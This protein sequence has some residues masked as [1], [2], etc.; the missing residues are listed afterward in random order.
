MSALR[1]ERTVSLGIIVTLAIQSAGALMWG[2]A[3]DARIKTLEQTARTSPPVAERL[4]RL[5]EQMNMARQ[6]LERIET[7]LDQKD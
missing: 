1:V 2:G 3:A 5:E 4:A 6:S 7:R